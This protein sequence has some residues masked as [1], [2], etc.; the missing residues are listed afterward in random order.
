[1]WDKYKGVAMEIGKPE[2]KEDGI[3]YIAWEDFKEMFTIVDVIFPDVGFDMV[4]YKVHESYHFCG[5]VTGCVVGCTEF[6]CLC[7][8]LKALW[9]ETSS[10]SRHESLLPHKQDDSFHFRAV[11]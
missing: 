5:T 9:F 1:M 6:W 4:H 10:H 8:G 3:F 11:V 7:R 2:G